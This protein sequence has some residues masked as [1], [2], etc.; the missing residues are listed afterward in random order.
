MQFAHLEH[1]KTVFEYQGSQIPFIGFDELTHF[2]EQQFFYMMSRLRSTSGVPGYIRATCNPD[3][4]SWVANFLDWWIDADGYAIPERAGVL[5]WFIRI[6]D[7]IVWANSKEE[8]K[9]LY[10]EDEMPRSVTFIP[11]KIYDNKI[12]LEKDPT[13]LASLKAL[14]SVD[15]QRLLGDIEKGGNWKIRASAG[16]V[17]RREW[18]QTVS[19]I[20]EGF[21]RV[22]RFWDRAATPPTPDNKD[23]DWTRGIKLY[24]YPDGTFVVGDMRSMRNTPGQVELLIKKTAQIDTIITRIAAQQDPGSAGVLE[25]THFTRMLAAYDVRTRSFSSN[26]VTRAKPVSAAAEFGR[27]KVLSAPWNAAFFNE[28]VSFPDGPHDDIV[29]ALSGAYNEVANTWSS[30]DSTSKAS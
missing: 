13:Y 14:S 19:S 15:R 7:E 30:V 18:F 3:A 8:I 23:P 11:S 28:L 29:D 21:T 5:R 12:L 27:I 26:K 16:K 24:A 6:G 17:F 10:G 4:D 1:E 22:V 20:P 2:T 9:E 25:A